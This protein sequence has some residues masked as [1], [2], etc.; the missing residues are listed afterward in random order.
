MGLF[1]FFAGKKKKQEPPVSMTPL[2]PW[3]QSLRDAEAA[4]GFAWNN[5]NEAA[6]SFVRGFLAQAAPAFGNGVIVDG[7]PP[8]YCSVG[9]VLINE[10]GG[11]RMKREDRNV[12]LRGAYEGV[13]ICIPVSIPGKRIWAIRIRCE[14]TGRYFTVVRDHSRIPRLIDPNDPWA[15]SEQQ[16]VFLG[17]GIFLDDEP[18]TRDSMITE[19]AKVPLAAQELV[20]REME[21]LD[22]RVVQRSNVDSAILLLMNAT[23]DQ[24]DDPIACLHSCAAFLAQLTKLLPSSEE[25]IF[26]PT[27]PAPQRVTCKYCSSIFLLAP[28][29]NACP[30]CGAPAQ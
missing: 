23:L 14:N 28:G 10:Y 22:L 30:N 7:E 24:L 1:D 19:W 21:R 2:S 8:D 29:E 17:K 26:A 27:G 18:I 13:P 5:D 11:D 6:R 16:C 4:R 15:K 9:V 12:E 3:Q 25:S 20:L